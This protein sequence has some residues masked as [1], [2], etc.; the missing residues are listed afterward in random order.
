MRSLI[1]VMVAMLAAPTLLAV[2]AA[3]EVP[4]AE[5]APWWASLI[6]LIITVI[7]APF[8][9]NFFKAKADAAK[10]DIDLAKMTKKER[11]VSSLKVY[12]LERAAAYSEKEMVT[13]SQ[14]IISGK[15]TQVE[16]IKDYLRKLGKNLK[17]DLIIFVKDS[18]GMDLIE[19]MG[20]KYVDELIE[21]VANR[22]SPF[23]GKDTA[24][25]LLQGGADKVVRYGINKADEYLD[26]GS[27]IAD[28]LI[29]AETGPQTGIGHQ[30]SETEETPVE[31]T[32]ELDKP[33]E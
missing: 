30:L 7:V 23:P 14:M 5:G 19:E 27:T 29:G 22:V 10:A 28:A 17:D 3:T 24:V 4:I 15:L 32:T 9:T 8:V 6:A 31:S 18:Y 26:K 2:E 25:A 13:I 33:S 20:N 21:A 12:A 11:M 16:A 1:L